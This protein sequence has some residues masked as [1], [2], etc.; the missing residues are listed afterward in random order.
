MNLCVKATRCSVNVGEGYSVWVDC[1][2]Y[3]QD[4]TL[5]AIN[6]TSGKSFEFY[7]NFY[8]IIKEWPGQTMPMILFG[9]CVPRGDFY[10]NE[11]MWLDAGGEPFILSENTS[12]YYM[13]IASRD[14]E[15]VF[16]MALTL[17]AI[18]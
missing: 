11:E 3:N 14:S 18:V 6:K 7:E 17:G 9:H 1:P 8:V 12:T 5:R 2:G 16:D 10:V 15:E 4:E 13:K